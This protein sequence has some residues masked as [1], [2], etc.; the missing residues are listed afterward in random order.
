[1]TA[2]SGLAVV[3]TRVADLEEKKQIPRCARDDN[4]NLRLNG[5]GN[6]NGNGV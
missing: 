6:G 3:I 4:V 1:M 5:N 2:E